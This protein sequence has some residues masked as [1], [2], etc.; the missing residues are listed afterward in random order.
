MFYTFYSYK[1]GTGRSMAMANVAILLHRRGLNVVALD[2]NLE[3][4][5]LEH[6]LF[7]RDDTS[8]GSRQGF[9]DLILD[10]KAAM[11]RPRSAHGG[12]SRLK[13]PAIKD[14][15]HDVDS[16][17]KSFLKL[18]PAGE[19]LGEK[20]KAYSEV[21]CRF[22]WDDFYRNWEGQT[23][24]KWLRHGLHQTADVVLINSSAGITEM[25]NICTRQ[26]ADA[27]VLFCPLDRQGRAG[28][29][30]LAFELA[31]RGDGTSGVEEEVKPGEDVV[32]ERR[33]RL[34][35]I[36]SRV[37]EDEGSAT[38]LESVRK[39]FTDD[40]KTFLPHDKKEWEHEY[41]WNLR[42][43]YVSAHS[44][45]EQLAA[46][47]E[48]LAESRP[49]VEAYERIISAMARLAPENSPLYQ[50]SED[51][52]HAVQ[53]S[54]DPLEGLEPYRGLDSF[55]EK[56]ARLFFG[57]DG[58]I[59]ELVTKV[60]QGG[61]IAVI[62]QSGCGKSSLVHA[63]L[64]PRVRSG[65][66]AEGK[67]W[68]IV[69]VTPDIHP[70]N[71]LADE[72]C[73]Q[74]TEQG[75]EPLGEP[76]KIAQ[77]LEHEEGSLAR[78]VTHLMK[79]R[80]EAT[81]LLLVVDQFE[82]LATLSDPGERSAFLRQMI[83]AVKEGRLIVVFTMRQDFNDEFMGRHPDF[84]AAVGERVLRL[85]KMETT[86][87]REA[88]TRPA[89]LMGLVFES[90]LV[91]RI[92][93]DVGEEP[94]NLPLLQFA[95][96][97]LWKGRDGARLT[98]QVY[99]EIGG[100]KGAIAAAAEKAYESLNAEE[101]EITRKIFTRLV[102]VSENK[103]G[104]N[105][106]RR[107]TY[108]EFSDQAKPVIKKLADARLL[109]AGGD[110]SG[111]A[112]EDSR[113]DQV[114]FAHEALIQN[115]PRL[116]Q[117]L[118]SDRE[119]LLWRQT[120]WRALNEWKDEGEDDAL[121]RGKSLRNA[122]EQL[123][124]R[125]ADLSESEVDFIAGSAAHQGEQRRVQEKYRR[126]R[127][128]GV[129]VAAVIILASL[130]YAWWALRKSQ[131]VADSSTYYF[132]GS[133]LERSGSV[134][135]AIENYG[136]AIELSPELPDPY[137]SRA[138]IYSRRGV[139][140]DYERAIKDFD[141]FISLKSESAIAYNGRGEVYRK[142]SVNN[143]QLRDSALRDFGEAIQKDAGFAPAWYN[144]A[145]VLLESGRL[146][147]AINAFDRAVATETEFNK[148][149]AN[150][151]AAPVDLP[152]IISDRG[153]A[154]YKRWE[155][156][157]KSPQDV[158]DALADFNQAI[159]L[160]PNF[161]E[162]YFQL[163]VIH[164]NANELTK[165]VELFTQAIYLDPENGEAYNERGEA[166]EQLKKEEAAF[167]DFSEAVNKGYQPALFNL[168]RLYLKRG[169]SEKA[170]ETFTQ[171]LNYKSDDARAYWGR[172][173]AYARKGEHAR[174]ILDFNQSI[175]LDQ[176]FLDPYLSRAISYSETNDRQRAIEDLKVFD[177]QLKRTDI[178]QQ[179]K[180]QEYLEKLFQA[181]LLLSKL[182]Y[183]ASPDDARVWLHYGDPSNKGLAEQ[184]DTA[185]RRAGFRKIVSSPSAPGDIAIV[186]YFSKTDSNNAARV[187]DE[188]TKVYASG[189]NSRK[190]K[191]SSL[192]SSA[193]KGDTFGLIEVWLTPLGPN[194]VQPEATPAPT[195][196]N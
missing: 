65:H 56:H 75:I 20:F 17:E 160:N 80:P 12:K 186:K 97:K 10:F 149:R 92:L 93:E 41:F 114:E 133:E 193:G 13:L 118:A 192:P 120:L 110:D 147:E 87:L 34:I 101:Q 116:G 196:E 38:L 121:L 24:F 36:P 46:R 95:L 126:R 169:E 42:V 58:C 141:K 194:T 166:R 156:T 71:K 77:M 25:G 86:G 108:A 73:R 129:A 70:L 124:K 123:G 182:G 83:A 22:D 168:G 31:G 151:G 135:A 125:A 85:G 54:P 64:V 176:S 28:T 159:A 104:P 90:G 72:L 26:L 57:R 45:A 49:M 138:F 142:L 144:W 8:G 37:E 1:G 175:A 43:P 195:P 19:R 11:S 150:T 143:P 155:A 145:S 68:R 40:F 189:G 100:V 76:A 180:S 157:N 158:Q 122:E 173:E 139:K 81:R 127:R 113:A 111:Q 191:L 4:P 53:S 18:M 128:A 15:L 59:K 50:L 171:A 82:E 140:D 63:G 131:N 134:Q 107:A 39:V 55:Y 66:L 91:D 48:G 60:E 98:H 88:V 35:V 14:Y 47:A 2:F 96:T 153:K 94:G 74:Q 103:D 184:V 188:I 84:A 5:S 99:A 137:L 62:G 51:K 165:A 177:E 9:V 164:A 179:Y 7:S 181:R 174:A 117:W 3:A 44:F 79:E 161:A 67:K 185:L 109:V 187:R 190:F 154:R 61:M 183:K 163:G 102:Q 23:F 27:V 78:L 105:T 167:V 21:I 115:W 152:H 130:G 32:A 106:R 29:L 146:D 172:G 33:T 69:I 6:Y 148:T 16:N 170:I 52:P 112:R 162:P 178:P 30:K 132:R 89:E 136:R 119:F